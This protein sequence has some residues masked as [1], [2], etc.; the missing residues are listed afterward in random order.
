M[1]GS[2][3]NMDKAKGTA[4]NRATGCSLCAPFLFS[5]LF[6]FTS[7]YFLFWSKLFFAFALLIFFNQQ[8][9]HKNKPQKLSA[10]LDKRC[11]L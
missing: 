2:N 11:G 5:L 10:L 3:E 6:S 4:N 1:K 9:A 8:G 7:F